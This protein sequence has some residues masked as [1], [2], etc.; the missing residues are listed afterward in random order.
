MFLSGFWGARAY[1]GCLAV[2]AEGLEVR[3][4]VGP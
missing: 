4:E 3:F 1:I 2:S